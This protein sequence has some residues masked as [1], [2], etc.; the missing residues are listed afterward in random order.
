MSREPLVLA[1]A[2]QTL[3]YAVLVVACLLFAEVAADSLGGALEQIAD[4]LRRG[5]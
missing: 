1:H 5:L 4:V 2:G 3:F